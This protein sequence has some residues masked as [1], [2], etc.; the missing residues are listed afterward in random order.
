MPLV[1]IHLL[2]LRKDVGSFKK[3]VFQGKAV[4]SVTLKKESSMEAGV[5]PSCGLVLIE[6]RTQVLILY[7]IVLYPRCRLSH[8]RSN[9]G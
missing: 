4:V 7:P 1:L 2:G 9:A 5:T 8:I 3:I 6:K